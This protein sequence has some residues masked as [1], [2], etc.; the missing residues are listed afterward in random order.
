MYE[1]TAALP[2]NING[3]EVGLPAVVGAMLD[4]S[5]LINSH[6]GLL[7]AQSIVNACIQPPDGIVRMP[8]EQ[9]KLLNNIRLQPA[10]AL[11]VIV[12]NGQ[13]LSRRHFISQLNAIR[14]AKKIEPEA[15]VAEAP[16]SATED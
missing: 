7:L 11:P 15:P 9:W 13:Q 6:D 10:V 4:G 16:T 14:D 1:V 2:L 5:T 3:E 12:V 8:D